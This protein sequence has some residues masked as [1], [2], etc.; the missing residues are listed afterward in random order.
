MFHNPDFHRQLG[1][2]VQ[3]DKKIN[4][5]LLESL[6]SFDLDPKEIKLT[7]NASGE[8]MS[9]YDVSILYSRKKLS[10]VITSSLK[11]YKD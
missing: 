11:L 7:Q 2:Y 1:V 9:F 10:P 3:N 8:F 4:D 5:Y 6:F